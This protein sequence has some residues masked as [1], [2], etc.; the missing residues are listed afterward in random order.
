M[1]RQQSRAYK[2][3]LSEDGIHLFL[4]C[5]CRLC[6]L[7]GDLLPY[8]TT[9]F[10]AVDLLQT[11]DD[12]DLATEVSDPALD[13]LGGRKIRHVGTSPILSHLI[14]G[15]CGTLAHSGAEHPIPQ[16]W[17]LFLAALAHM[18]VIEDREIVRSFR[19]MPGKTGRPPHRSA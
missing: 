6:H 14:E 15:I 7:V 2:L 9:L 11:C 19:N 17:K 4:R 8:G 18:Q 10:I 16:V 12:Q 13:G 5:H 3:Q 1:A